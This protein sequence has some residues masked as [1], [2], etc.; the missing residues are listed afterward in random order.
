MITVPT[1]TFAVL[2]KDTDLR[3]GPGKRYPYWV[4]VSEGAKVLVETKTK[5]ENGYTSVTTEDGII[6]FL[7]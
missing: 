2:S 3:T 7:V 4:E 1:H 6:I 5:E